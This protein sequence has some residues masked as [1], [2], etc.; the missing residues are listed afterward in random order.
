MTYEEALELVGKVIRITNAEDEG[1]EAEIEID[2][3]IGYDWWNDDDSNTAKAIKAKLK[4][5]ANLKAKKINVRINSFG[6]YVH[7]GLAIHDALAAN[8]AEILT[9]VQ[10][11][12][13]SMATV[14]AQAGNERLM[15]DNALY[16][17]HQVRGGAFGN[18]NETKAHLDDLI[19]W[20]DRLVN[21][22]VKRT[23]MKEKDIRELMDRNNG[24]GIWIDA[25][26]ALEMGLIDKVYEPMQAAASVKNIN[27]DKLKAMRMPAIPAGKRNIKNSTI[28]S[29]KNTLMKMLTDLKGEIRTMLGLD[30]EQDLPEDVISKLTEFNNR[31]EAAETEASD[32]AEEVTRLTGELDAAKATITDKETEV[33][34]LMT[35]VSELEGKLTKLNSSSTKPKG[36]QGAEDDNNRLDKDAAEWDAEAQKIRNDLM[37]THGD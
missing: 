21:I 4:A 24:E 18:I 12:A 15:S 19:A 8:K 9:D 17:I 26:E 14:I 16:L 32:N 13:A 25:D 1:G 5:I 27:P 35:K 7:E 28:M 3:E 22:Y 10:G 33:S 20:N 31:I 37:F 2:G 30:S 29:D 36:P 23:G 11:V 6:G 34:N